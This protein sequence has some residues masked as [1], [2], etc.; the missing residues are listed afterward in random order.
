MNTAWRRFRHWGGQKPAFCGGE[1]EAYGVWKDTE[2]EEVCL[3]ILE[4]LSR[5]ENIKIVCEASGKLPA[6]KDVEVDLGTVAEDY[7]KYSDVP[8]YGFFDRVYLPNGMWSTLK[9]IGSAMI[10]GEM[11]VEESVKIMEDDYNTL[12]N[13]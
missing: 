11:S 5:P 9:T 13:Q 4:Y 6:I 12:R 7:A 10:A 3:A 2:N 8:M 1:R